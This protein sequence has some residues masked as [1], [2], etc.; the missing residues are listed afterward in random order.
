MSTNG[1]IYKMNWKN[2]NN[3]FSGCGNY[4]ISK[5]EGDAW[6]IYL[7]NKY[8]QIFHWLSDL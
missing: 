2:L 7:N 8:P 1:N 5:K 4:M 3:N 6:I